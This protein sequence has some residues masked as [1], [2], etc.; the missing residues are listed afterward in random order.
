MKHNTSILEQ[1]KN[2]T[3]Y[4]KKEAKQEV[5]IFRQKIKANTLAHTHKMLQGKMTEDVLISLGF[6]H[7]VKKK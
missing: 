7:G 3:G 2:N 1:S 4:E 6:D 5:E